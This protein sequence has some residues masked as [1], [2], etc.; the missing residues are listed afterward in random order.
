ME[1]NNLVSSIQQRKSTKITK[2][3]KKQ[4]VK[5]VYISN[6]MKVKASAADFRSLVQQLTGQDA[7]F[8]DPTKFPAAAIDVDVGGHQVV[9]ESTKMIRDDDDD[10]AVVDEVASM[11][12]SSCHE[13]PDSS[14][15]TSLF[16]P[17]DDAFMPQMIENLSGVFPAALLYESFQ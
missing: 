4:P 6:P 15:S 3:K 17:F 16:E 2:T 10:E 12:T 14:G 13:Q 5:V 7:E 1:S 9:T 8:P 11:E